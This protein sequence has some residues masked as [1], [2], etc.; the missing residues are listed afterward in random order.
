[1]SV[2]MENY[3]FV[4]LGK[5]PI[6]IWIWES[7]LWDRVR[8]FCLKR[9]SCRRVASP[10]GLRYPIRNGMRTPTSAG[11]VNPS[12]AER[13]AEVGSDGGSEGLVTA[14]RDG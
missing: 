13:G 14:R 10:P 12:P 5:Q 2:F 6:Q 1:M 3:P 7:K 8:E 4:L 11:G 9:A